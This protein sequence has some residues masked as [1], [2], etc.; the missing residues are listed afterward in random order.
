MGNP[1]FA[2]EVDACGLVCP[3]PL[4]RTKKALQALE[5]GQVVKVITTDKNAVG[6]FQAFAKQTGHLILSQDS[7]DNEH[8]VHFIQKR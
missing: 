6:D 8:I 3:L 7:V 1:D 5:S 2:V 4:L